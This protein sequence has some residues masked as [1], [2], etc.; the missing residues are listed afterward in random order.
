[1]KGALSHIK[2]NAQT[3]KE[4][5]MNDAIMFGVGIYVWSDVAKFYN[6][7][8]DESN[9]ATTKLNDLELEKLLNKLLAKDSV[10]YCQ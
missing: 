3:G 7:K 9:N 1:M 2:R 8:N 10:L 6:V 5:T 4:K